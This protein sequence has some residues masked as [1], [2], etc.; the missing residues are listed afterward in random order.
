MN[1]LPSTVAIARGCA[2][3]KSGAEWAGSRERCHSCVF[4]RELMRRVGIVSDEGNGTSD[5]LKL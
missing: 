4:T 2:V 3:V 1:R 5:G